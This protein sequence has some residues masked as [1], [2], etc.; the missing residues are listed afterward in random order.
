MEKARG[1]VIRDGK[2]EDLTGG[3]RND[4]VMKRRWKVETLEKRRTLS[5]SLILCQPKYGSSLPIYPQEE[6]SSD[7]N[8]RP[9]EDRVDDLEVRKGEDDDE[10]AAVAKAKMSAP[11]SSWMERE[12]MTRRF[13]GRVEWV[14]DAKEDLARVVLV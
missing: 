5:R 12:K 2:I 3:W 7:E 6:E 11:V 10:D 14:V 1:G 13:I 4:I 9:S 8:I